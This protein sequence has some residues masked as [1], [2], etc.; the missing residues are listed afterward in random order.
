MHHI[1]ILDIFLD[2]DHDLNLYLGLKS[3]IQIIILKHALQASFV[4]PFLSIIKFIL[5]QLQH[6]FLISQAVPS[7][8]LGPARS[9]LLVLTL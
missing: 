8:H 6:I 2:T 3:W 9:S 5:I 7:F 1:I 4:D